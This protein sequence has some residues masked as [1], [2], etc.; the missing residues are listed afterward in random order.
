MKRLVRVALAAAIALVALSAAAV[1]AGVVFLRSTLPRTHGRARL[2]GLAA[3]VSVW[4]D[5]WGVPTI[6]ASSM[7][8]AV[9]ALGYVHA[10]DRLWQME[11]RRRGALGRLSEIFGPDAV[12]AD[13]E[14]RGYDL[15]SLARKD[16]AAATEGV[17]VIHGRGRH[18]HKHHPVLKENIQRWL[19]TRRMSRHVIAYTSARRCDGGGGAVYVLLRK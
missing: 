19:C 9:M 14:Q 18:S 2:P 6:R 7:P 15:E 1:I 16:L 4:R 8:D 10:S 11:M 17:R 5:R 13:F 12:D 3:P